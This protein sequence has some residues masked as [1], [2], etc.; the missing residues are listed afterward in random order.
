M[1]K[2]N[3]KKEMTGKTTT[4]KTIRKRGAKAQKAPVKRG[5]SNDLIPIEEETWLLQ[6]G[7]ASCRER[8][9]CSV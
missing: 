5:I 9:L 7:R 2:A 1:A 8:V 4:K 6:I 3:N